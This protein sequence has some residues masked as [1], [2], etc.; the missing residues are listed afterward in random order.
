MKERFILDTFNGITIIKQ[1]TKKQALEQHE[2]KTYGIKGDEGK[3]I[4]HDKSLPEQY[5]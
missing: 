2:Q 1:P 4:N 5:P 3:I